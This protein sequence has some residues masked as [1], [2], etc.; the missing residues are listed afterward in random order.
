MLPCFSHSSRRDFI[1][2]TGGG[3]GALALS[4]LL[5]GSSARGDD[6]G[7]RIDPLRPFAPRP[8]HFRAKAR[9]VIFLFQV[10]GPSQVDT[11]DYKPT[12]QRLHGGVMQLY[13]ARADGRNVYPIT[14]V[15][16]GSCAMHGHWQPVL[17][18]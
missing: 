4:A 3:F 18:P 5:A 16:A 12:L 10:G 2:R 1:H 8:P 15:E 17:G 7:V 14:R 11:F 9:S 13:V 6:P